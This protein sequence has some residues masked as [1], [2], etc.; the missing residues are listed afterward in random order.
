MSSY[1]YQQVG[2]SG[3]KIRDPKEVRQTIT[4]ETPVLVLL[5]AGKGTRFGTNPK[6]IAPVLGKPLARHSIDG[7]YQF[8]PEAKVLCVVGYKHEEV[9]GALGDD[10]VYV[11]SDNPVGGTA[12]A[13]Y[14]AF[15]APELIE[16]NPPVVISM[17]D[18]I[19][20]AEIFRR[21][22][23]VHLGQEAGSEPEDVRGRQADL[24]MLTAI[25]DESRIKGKGRIVRNEEKRIVRIME[26]RD[27]LALTD[28]DPAEGGEKKLLQNVFLNLCE[29]NCPLYVIRA[30]KL[31]ELLMLLSNDNAQ[32]Q[33]YL[34]D[35]IEKIAS[36]GGVIRSV[37]VRHT[38]PEFSILCADV[39]RADDIPRLESVLIE[40]GREQ[41]EVSA[42]AEVI[43]ADRPAGQTASIRRQLAELRTAIAR[44]KL[45]FDPNAPFSIGIAGGRFRIAFMHPD[46]GRFYGPAWQVP[47][48]ADR[49]AGM[50]QIVVFLQRADDRRLHLYP[51]AEQFRETVDSID[52]D[53]EEMYPDRSISDWYAY[54]Q[55]GTNMSER[56]LLSLGYFSDEEIDRRRSE[57]TPLP[58]E[59]LWVSNSMRRPFSLVGNALASLRTYRKGEAG[60]R[61]A[62]ALGKGEF[63]GL[64]MVST[65]LIPQGGFSCSSALT[66]A[67][68]NA[69]SALY[70]LDLSADELI[71][72]AA[73][74]EYGTGVRAGSLDQATVQKGRP[75]VGTLISS[76]PRDRYAILG[77]F[78]FPSDR[79]SVIFPYTTPRDSGVWKWS[80][81]FYA[82][83]TREE[84]K[85][86]GR[87]TTSEMRKLTGK[88]AEIAALLV[89]QPIDVDFFDEIKD[90]LLDD[91]LLTGESR[92]RIADIL[93]RVPLWI[94]KKELAEQIRGSVSF[95]EEELVRVRRIPQEAV[96]AMAKKTSELLL[97]GWREPVFRLPD[98]TEK[99]GVP[100]RAILAYLYGE[101]AKNFFMIHHPDRWIEMVTA[102]Q[103]GD[104][105]FELDESAVPSR[106][107]L[108]GLL[109]WEKDVSGPERLRLWLG[110][111]GARP[112]DFN[113][114]LDDGTLK[115]SPPVFHRLRGGNFFRG[116]ALVDLAE[117][118]LKRAFGSETAAVRVNAAGQGDYFQI[119]LDRSLCSADEV[120]L[121]MRKAFYDRFGI[122]PEIDF[123][124][125]HDGGGAVGISLSRYSSLDRLIEELR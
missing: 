2:L 38:D 48:G 102:S 119:H 82:S 9:I 125:I 21:I 116:L 51:L 62:A 24:T 90:D 31:M 71:E 5:A 34:T 100:L 78:R 52:A 8:S 124:D 107:E 109:D 91:G 89:R 29:G 11:V 3:E 96:R 16:K 105:C 81:G 115:S 26:E 17:G 73:Q 97:T 37:T 65:G 64:R 12:W 83:D 104:R 42:A 112:F 101:M 30:R 58:P 22:M 80:G 93:L 54:E 47:I 113:E 19:V 23:A 44:E 13:V 103:R 46:M 27:I 15:S 60:K 92:R 94:R 66:I 7:F 28:A 74:A 61:I 41:N 86:S 36:E 87:L 114:G 25:Y 63:T 56:L 68:K 77:E 95:Y 20:P 35:I 18:R 118:F 70:H 39:T 32:K 57:G 99:A 6:C 72:L 10:A 59:S 50:E 76:N 122:H 79:I 53:R 85:E 69:L 33:Y 111:L 117:A 55:F 1:I 84:G 67:V 123:I 43:R 49:E 4:G 120:K 98:G 121:F 108:E 110:R 45:D 106:A 88:A 14:E 75:G 40:T